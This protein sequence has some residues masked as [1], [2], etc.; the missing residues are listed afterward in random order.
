MNRLARRHRSPFSAARGYH[1]RPFVGTSSVPPASLA[2]VAYPAADRNSPFPQSDP[3]D[4]GSTAICHPYR[5]GISESAEAALVDAVQILSLIDTLIGAIADAQAECAIPADSL[6]AMTH[7]LHTLVHSAC[8]GIEAMEPA[9][10][11][12]W[13]QELNAWREEAE[14]PVGKPSTGP[15]TGPE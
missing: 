2:D 12:A 5:S 14:G 9:V 3:G 11:A 13:Q 1:G 15:D 10:Q 7:T 4:P 8:N 6:A